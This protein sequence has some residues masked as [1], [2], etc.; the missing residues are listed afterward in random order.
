VS[1]DPGWVEF[2][3][4]SFDEASQGLS[5]VLRITGVDPDELRIGQ[6]VTVHNLQFRQG[7]ADHLASEPGDIFVTDLGP[8]IS[9]REL[10]QIG[11][12]GNDKQSYAIQFTQESA[13]LQSI[14]QTMVREHIFTIPGGSSF[15]SDYA[16]KVMRLR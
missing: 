11:V 2:D 9:V 14:R 13:D 1:E 8:A 7:V 3:P 15:G 5:G 6:S 10:Q 12:F 4:E 16:Y